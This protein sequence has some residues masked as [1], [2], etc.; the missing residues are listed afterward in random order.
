MEGSVRRRGKRWYY[1][2]EGAKI[3]GKRK[4]YER[5]GGNT[6]AEALEALR[7]AINQYEQS[8][9]VQDLSDISV[10]DYF[11]YWYE[12]YV[13]RNLKYN[14]QQNYRNI[15]DHH[16]L[17]YIGQY[18]LK[19]VQPMVIQK[20]ID[21]NFEKGLAKQT[22]AIIRTVLSGALKRAVYPYQY[23]ASDPTR[24]IQMPRYD[25]RSRKTTSD[26]KVITLD[27]FQKLVKAIDPSHPYYMPMM[28]AFN[29]GLRRGE[30]LGLT[31]DNIDLSEGT[32]TVDKNIIT[33]K[34]SYMVGTLKT[35]S[36]YRTIDI[37]DSLTNVLKAHRKRQ[38]E[39]KLFYGQHYTDSNFICTRENGELVTPNSVKYHSEKLR[40]QTG[41]NFS[42]HS[43]RHTH[44]TLLLENGAIDKAIQERLGHSRIS[45][46]IDT[47]SHLTK[48]TKKETVNIFENLMNQ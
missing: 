45:T 27:D 5:V 17:P 16:I 14:T 29:T 13:M 44:A 11:N 1:A 34:K 39:N 35:Q 23:I 19:T 41:V 43:F 33:V 7:K 15:I 6:K 2:F 32:L 30:V 10:H 3:D 21:E 48:K 42:F 25:Q 47:Y 28:I 20:V 22:L 9:I 36:S 46:T 38:M 18:R 8:G 37:G 12:D 4:R 40:K 26:L 31:W 24:Y